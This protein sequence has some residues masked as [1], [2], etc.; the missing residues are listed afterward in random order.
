M[1]TTH[2]R[3]S[4]SWADTAASTIGRLYGY[5]TPPLPRRQLYIP[6]PFLRNYKLGFARRKSLAGFM[7]ATV[8]GFAITTAFWGY[9]APFRNEPST[10]VGGGWKLVGVGL[11]S[12]L[13]SGVVEALGS[14]L[15]T[16]HHN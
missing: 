12:G 7:A 2:T 3:C 14:Y 11:I 10:L 4:L 9:F 5:L 8:T 1:I 6:L 16:H 13:I 15:A